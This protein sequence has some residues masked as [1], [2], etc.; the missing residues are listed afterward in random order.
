MDLFGL[1]LEY[2]PAT[3]TIQIEGRVTI[4]ELFSLVGLIIAVISLAI[5]VRAAQDNARTRRAEFSFRVWQAFMQ[6]DVQSAYLDIEW[7]RFE[8][9]EGHTGFASD[10]QERGIDRLLYLLDEVAL[11]VEGGI[12]TKADYRRW[13]Y[14]GIRVMQ[15]DSIRN[16]LNFLDGFFKSNG[17]DRRPHDDARRVF[18]PQS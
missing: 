14:Q 2:L 10:A 7:G 18:A 9:G 16:Y 17:V 6:D 5:A 1:R 13:A 4:F 8:Y 12:L 15:D 11:L 3:S